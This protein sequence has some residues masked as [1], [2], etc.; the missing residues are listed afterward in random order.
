[1][2]EAAPYTYK[3]LFLSKEDSRNSKNFGYKYLMEHQSEFVDISDST[4]E[5]QTYDRGTT[6]MV[7]EGKVYMIHKDFVFLEKAERVFLMVTYDA[8][9]D[10]YVESGDSEETEE[11]TEDVTIIK[12]HPYD[13]Y[14]Q[15]ILRHMEEESSESEKSEEGS[16]ESSE[17]TEESEGEESEEKP[18]E[19]SKED[20]EDND[21]EEVKES[22][23]S[24]E[25]TE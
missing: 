10:A 9:I 14:D 12:K 24:V 21:G 1:M 16:E 18:A 11:T 5:L 20:S 17:T 23:E 22:E 7:Y 19:E 25:V 13:Q 6:Q 2:A 4:Y 3:A 8:E 15:N